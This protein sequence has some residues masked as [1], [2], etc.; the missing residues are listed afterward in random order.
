MVSKKSKNNS[1]M[2]HC[3]STLTLA[4]GIISFGLGLGLWLNYFSLNE[5]I[6]LVLVLM[7][8]K[9]VIYSCC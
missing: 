1:C 9:K 5:V 3:N 7:G 4:K 6:A 8:I 2:C